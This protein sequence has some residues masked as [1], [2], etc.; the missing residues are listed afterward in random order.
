M[1]TVTPCWGQSRVFKSM[2]RLGNLFGLSLSAWRD[3]IDCNYIRALATALV[4]L[5]TAPDGTVD[6]TATL[7][8]L[9]LR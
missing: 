1:N 4:A 6:L 8:R 5:L 7:E 2:V 3:R 9:L